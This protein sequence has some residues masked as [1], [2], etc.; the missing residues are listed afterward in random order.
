MT[1]TGKLKRLFLGVLM[2][3][4]TTS[5]FAVEEYISKVYSEIDVVF[6]KKSDEDLE[7]VLK[8]YLDDKYYY[9]LENYSKKKVR[10]LI[11][12]E[13]YEFAMTAIYVIIDANIDGDFEDDEAVDMYSTIAE[14]YELKQQAEVERLEEERI[15]REKKEAQNEKIRSKVEGDYVVANTTDGKQVYLSSKD[16]KMSSHKWHANFNL[17]TLG[18]MD[19]FAFSKHGLNFGLSIDGSYA[20]ELPAMIFGVDLFGDFQFLGMGFNGKELPMLANLEIAPKISLKALGKKVFARLGFA[21][22]VPFKTEQMTESYGFYGQFITPFAGIS[23]ENINLGKAT[24]SFGADW[25][26]GHLFKPELTAA[27]S[28]RFNIAIPFAEMEKS[29]LNFNF[30]LRDYLFIK[31]NGVENRVSAVIGFGVENVVR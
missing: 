3:F 20:Y 14:A 9:L 26:A 25:L 29:N 2:L 10:R 24:L 4:F 6:I 7:H 23:V 1:F 11:I 18:L 19:D 5:L 17:I 22:L 13:D 15:A 28:G 30:G 16:E 8:E 27:A 21:A 31:D 12:E